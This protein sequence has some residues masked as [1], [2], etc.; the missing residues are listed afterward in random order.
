MT[1][2]DDS[3]STVLGNPRGNENTFL[4][5]FGILWFRFHNYQAD[6]ISAQHAN[7]SHYTDERIFNEARK[8]VIGVHQ[9][10][11]T[12]DWLPKWLCGVDPAAD[13]T[14]LDPYIDGSKSLSPF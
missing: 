11:V 10:I 13:C 9:K 7:D 2:S 5:T 4:L 1:S 14:G 8:M 12:K 6:K 3:L